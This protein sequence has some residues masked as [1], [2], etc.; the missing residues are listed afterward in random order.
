MIKAMLTSLMILILCTAAY[1]QKPQNHNALMSPQDRPATAM[2]DSNPNDCNALL[3][4]GVFDEHDI[5]GTSYQLSIFLNRFCSAHYTSYSQAASDSLNIGVPIDG[6]MASLGFGDAQQN[7]GVDYR[8]L[9]SQQD[10]YAQSNSVNSEV[11]R[12]ADA[13]LAQAF[14]SCVNGQVFSAYITPTDKKQFQLNINYRPTGESPC[15]V[16]SF[17]YD[18]SLVSCDTMPNT[19][20]PEGAVVNCKRNDENSAVQLSLITT[21]GKEGFILPA[22]AAPQP[23]PAPV[24]AVGDVIASLLPADKFAAQHSNETWVLADGRDVSGSKYASL[25]G[26]PKVPDLRG[27]FLRGI[28]AGRKDQYADPD[29]ERAPGSVQLDALQDHNHPMNMN[30]RNDWPTSGGGVTRVPATAEGP[31]TRNTGS[32]MGARVAD[33]TRGKN[34]AV[35]YYV[36]IN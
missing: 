24:G 1:S 28:N 32:P 3:K 16:T 33:E 18:R 22:Y 35:Y 20:G 6:L 2:L 11:I 4:D 34:A 14:T 36:R 5:Y 19:I 15:K 7:F 13:N 17:K 12:N 30:P 23:P 26:N 27:L 9:C 25:T 31:L 10:S 21:Q 29:G 8:T